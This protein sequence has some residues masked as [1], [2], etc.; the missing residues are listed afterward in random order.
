MSHANN[1]T[2]FTAEKIIEAI[3]MAGGDISGASVFLGVSFKSLN[4]HVYRT[5]RLR[6]LFAK[7]VAKIPG[8]IP[9][10]IEQMVRDVEIPD[11]R[12]NSP[13]A[14]QSRAMRALNLDVMT[15]GLGHPG[16]VTGKQC[17]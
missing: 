12:D 7:D 16:I 11:A 10:E 3:N 4:E 13:E 5:P 8:N 9:D 2:D 15:D 1:V 14:R 17:T 6:A